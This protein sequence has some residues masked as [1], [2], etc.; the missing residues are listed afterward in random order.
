MTDIS[1]DTYHAIG[2]IAS[3]IDVHISEIVLNKSRATEVRN[4][5]K[6]RN[7]LRVAKEILY[8]AI[9]LD[10]IIG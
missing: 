4:L 9:Q 10:E 1:I 6:A 2:D 8:T 3:E 5:I 7:Q